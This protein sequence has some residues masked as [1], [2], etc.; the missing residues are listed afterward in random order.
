MPAKTCLCSL[1]RSI[2]R[3]TNLS[4]PSTCSA[5]IIFPIRRSTL[6]NVSIVISVL[7]SLAAFSVV[8][9]FAFVLRI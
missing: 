9:F 3:Q 4:A 7:F 5:S 6:L 1:P 2:F 8:I